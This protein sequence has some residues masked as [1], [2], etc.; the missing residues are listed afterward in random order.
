MKK[1]K[2]GILLDFMALSSP[3]KRDEVNVPYNH[4]TYE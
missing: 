4:Y 3:Y 2:D 1:S